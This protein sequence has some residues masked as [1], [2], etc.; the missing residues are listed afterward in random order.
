MPDSGLRGMTRLADTERYKSLF[1]NAPVELPEVTV[2]PASGSSENIGS[3]QG[4]T[5]AVVGGLGDEGSPLRRRPRA[6]TAKVNYHNAVRRK[7]SNTL[8]THP[9]GHP[10]GLNI[11]VQ[12]HSELLGRWG[13]GGGNGD[14]SQAATVVG[15]NA[16]GVKSAAVITTANTAD[17]ELFRWIPGAQNT[18]PIV[19]STSIAAAVRQGTSSS[20][21][22]VAS[23]GAG[24][25]NLQLAQFRRMAAAKRSPND[26]T[27][28]WVGAV[29][30]SSCA[31]SFG[32]SNKLAVLGGFQGEQVGVEGDGT[33][34]IGSAE[35]LHKMRRERRGS[36]QAGARGAVARAAELNNLHPPWRPK[37]LASRQ[38]AMSTVERG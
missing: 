28:G 1:T 17:E 32:L 26:V 5:D 13:E 11:H 21:N 31:D 3:R 8:F 18:G 33:S 14:F 2:V 4:E 27:N 19:H 35:R 25:S 7:S 20:Y 16:N 29:Y 10:S 9:I 30:D 36:R 24:S 15:G 23:T 38:R 22:K 37:G 34:G 12:S 6:Q